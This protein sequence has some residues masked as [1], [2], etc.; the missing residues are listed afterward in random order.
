MHKRSSLIVTLPLL[1]V[2][3]LLVLILAAPA[4]ARHSMR[5]DGRRVEVGDSIA[6]VVS[7]FGEPKMKVDLGEIDDGVHNCKVELWV[8]E[9]FPWRYELK[10][11]RGRIWV[12]QKIRLRKLR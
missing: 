4:Y 2:L 12:L 10:I 8:Y 11:K 5:H 3:S 1:T 7:Q 9:W 6:D